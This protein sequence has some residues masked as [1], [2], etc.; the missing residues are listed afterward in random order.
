MDW[1]TNVIVDGNYAYITGYG[2]H[3]VTAI[4]ITDPT[5]ISAA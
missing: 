3:A 5:S 2:S 1:G 4:D